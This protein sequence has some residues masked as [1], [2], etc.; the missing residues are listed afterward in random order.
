VPRSQQ[1]EITIDGRS[2]RISECPNQ[3]DATVDVGGRIYLCN[4]LH[5]RN[6]ARAVFDD[7]VA[8]IDLTPET[9]VDVPA[10]TIDLTPCQSSS[11]SCSR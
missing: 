8:T 9:A 4:M 6:D 2:G 1:A 11:R 10:A 5:D 7:W 3:I